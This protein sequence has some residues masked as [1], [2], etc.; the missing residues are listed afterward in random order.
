PRGWQ[1]RT[2]ESESREWHSPGGF[3]EPTA[4]PRMPRGARVLCSPA[5]PPR[6]VFFLS[7]RPSA[8]SPLWCAITRVRSA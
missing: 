5:S 8:R 7:R 1:K 6:L 3:Q 4:N 2:F